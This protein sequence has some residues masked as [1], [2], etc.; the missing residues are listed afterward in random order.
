MIIWCSLCSFWKASFIQRKKWLKPS[1]FASNRYE[2][3]NIFQLR[4]QVVKK[5]TWKHGR[6]CQYP[7]EKCA[8]CMV[9]C[10]NLPWDASYNKRENYSSSTLYILVLKSFPGD[11]MEPH[12]T[13]DTNEQRV[14]GDVWGCEGCVCV[15]TSLCILFPFSHR[16]KNHDSATCPSMSNFTPEISRLRPHPPHIRS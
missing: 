5:K 13:R 8:C 15:S 10:V 14:C 9:G 6:D 3:I 16:I 1:L 12:W 4:K 11:F 7:T 2:N